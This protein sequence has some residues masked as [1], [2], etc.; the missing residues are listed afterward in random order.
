MRATNDITIPGADFAAA[1]RRI[2]PRARKKDLGGVSTAP[3]GAGLVLL[4][5]YFA[6]AIV[7]AEGTWTDTVATPAGASCAGW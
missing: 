2:L 5:G 1:I 6:S 3:A 7:P 4:S